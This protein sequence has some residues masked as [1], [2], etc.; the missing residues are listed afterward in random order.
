M[1][2]NAALIPVERIERRI[3][4]LRGHKVMLDFDLAELYGVEVRL[5]NQAVKRNLDRFPDDF[6]IQLSW[7]EA[8]AVLRSQTVILNAETNRKL[9]KIQ[10]SLRSQNVTLKRGQHLKFRPY[11][12]TEQGVAMLSSVLRSPRAVQVNIAIMRAFVQ[13]RQMLA[14]NVNLARK[15]AALE[16]KYDEQF[17]VVFDAIRELMSRPEPIRPEHGREIGFHFQSLPATRRRGTKK[18]VSA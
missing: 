5:L 7:E 12:F 4:L 1:S 11:A 16:E 17:K 13:L 2:K 3:L 6:M 10:H 15:L 8:E 18:K 14:S 9:R